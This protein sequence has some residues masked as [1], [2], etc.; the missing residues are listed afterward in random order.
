MPTH[1]KHVGRG[2]YVMIDARTGKVVGHSTSRKKAEKF[3]AIRDR[4]YR[5]GKH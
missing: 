2:K 5:R 3:R 4:D 1:I